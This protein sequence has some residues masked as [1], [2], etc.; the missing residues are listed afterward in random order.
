V[1]WIHLAEDRDQCLALMNRAMNFRVF[2]EAKLLSAFKGLWTVE[3]VMITYFSINIWWI[4]DD[5][6]KLS[7]VGKFVGKKRNLLGRSGV[8]K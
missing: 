4:F 6:N 1:D 3:L 2:I 8:S 7:A 5:A